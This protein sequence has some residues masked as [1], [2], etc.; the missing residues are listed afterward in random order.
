MPMEIFVSCVGDL[1]TVGGSVVVVT[2][3]VLPPGYLFF[4]GGGVVRPWGLESFHPGSFL[5]HWPS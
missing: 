5:A 4:W 2:W 1:A 3:S